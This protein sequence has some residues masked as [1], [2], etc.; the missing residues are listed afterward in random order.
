MTCGMAGIS[1][2]LLSASPLGP[3]PT[4]FGCSAPVSTLQEAILL[5]D[6]IQD[7]PTQETF[8]DALP[9]TP[10]KGN[11]FLAVPLK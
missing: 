6:R 4:G 8:T 11:I 5:E 7:D 1:I 3:F 9:V 10:R 2:L